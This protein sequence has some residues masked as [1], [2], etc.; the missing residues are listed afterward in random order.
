M[1]DLSCEFICGATNTVTSPICWIN[2]LNPTDSHKSYDVI[3]YCMHNLVSIV[4]LSTFQ[5]TQTL[6]G[7]SGRI[8][9]IK[10]TSSYV[11][12]CSDDST[13]RVW[14]IGIDAFSPWYEFAVL[15]DHKKTSIMTVACLEN[16]FGT[17]VVSAN[18]SGSLSVWLK[19]DSSDVN[20]SYLKEFT[21]IETS[22]YSPSQM[23]HELLIA[24]LPTCQ[25]DSL[26]IIHQKQTKT[27]NFP[28]IVIF[29]GCVDAKI[30]LRVASASNILNK[31]NST[32]TEE[33]INNIQCPDSVIFKPVGHLSGHE[34][35]ITTLSAIHIT[36]MNSIGGVHNSHQDSGDDVSNNRS[37]ALILASGSQDSKI[38][39]WKFNVSPSTTI[40]K[41]G[42]SMVS[43][44][45]NEFEEEE[46][47]NVDE[48]EDEVLLDAPDDAVQLAPD[49]E[50][51]EARLVFTVNNESVDAST[52]KV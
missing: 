52:S 19:S 18:V 22:V 34:E 26:N 41:G 40:E 47:Q 13:I 3:A 45:L 36:D 15:D 51:G 37:N 48:D 39:L 25:Q 7:H 44:K 5:V 42:K 10:S 46:F 21:L 24:E 20:T 8:N 16:D 27:K 9:T 11:I 33:E 6:R 38:R 32:V 1:L 4:D 12:T 29:I 28:D 43:T 14:K 49:E 23:P 17:F 2:F 30:H 35:W 50:L 31:I